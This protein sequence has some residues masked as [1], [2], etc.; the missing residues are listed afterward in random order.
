MNDREHRQRYDKG[1]RIATVTRRYTLVS[2]C[3]TEGAVI[4]DTYGEALMLPKGSSLQ[5]DKGALTG[6]G[7]LL[8]QPD[9]GRET[10]TTRSSDRSSMR[11]GQLVSSWRSNETCQ[12]PR[13]DGLNNALARI[14][15]RRSL[16]HAFDHAPPV[17]CGAPGR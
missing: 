7:C 10:S 17:R 9:I 15:D 6:H 4:G 8:S 1:S 16:S 11:A 12:T 2:T 5:I 14:M 13:D 3:M